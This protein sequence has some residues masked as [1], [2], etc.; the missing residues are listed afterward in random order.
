VEIADRS[1]RKGLI[2][3]LVQTP[4]QTARI[5]AALSESWHVMPTTPASFG[6][7]CNRTDL[8]II[9]LPMVFRIVPVS[10]R[11]PLLLICT[12]EEL[13]ALTGNPA[14]DDVLVEPWSTDELRYRVRRLSSARRIRLASAEF[15][16]SPNSLSV[17]WQGVSRTLPLSPALFGLFDLLVRNPGTPV[18]RTRLTEILSSTA[19]SGDGRSLDMAISRLRHKLATLFDQTPIGPE[20]SA[21]RGVGYSL[22]LHAR[23]PVDNS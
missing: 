9:D 15:A 20:I 3:V 13:S 11:V 14:P 21:H 7:G 18:A 17:F 19:H 2:R 4:A 10:V 12:S 1:A 5:A 23:S 8:L 22:S 16:W 6:S